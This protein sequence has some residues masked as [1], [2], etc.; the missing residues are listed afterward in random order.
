[1]SKLYEYPSEML[2][3]LLMDL[4]NAASMGVATA[5]YSQFLLRL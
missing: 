2:V 1:M 4:S 3:Q 5:P